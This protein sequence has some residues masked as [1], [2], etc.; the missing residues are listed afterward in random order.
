[1]PPG[2][3][4]ARRWNVHTF[5]SLRHRDFRV[6]WLGWLGVGAGQW[7][8]LLVV[9]WF[10]LE[11]TDSAFMVGAVHG[12]R[13]IPFLV[14]SPL[15]GV[16]ADRFDRRLLLA[17]SQSVGVLTASTMAFLDFSGLIEIWH[18]FVLTTVFGIGWSINNPVR[19]AIVPQLVEREDLM[20]AIALN[21][22][23]FNISRATGPLMAAV[24][25]ATLGFGHIFAIT[26]VLYAIV[27]M[28]ILSV[29]YRSEPPQALQESLWENLTG[30]LRYL[31]SQPTI[32]TLLAF[33]LFP[34]FVGMPYIALMPVFARDVLGQDELGFAILMTVAGVGSLFST[35]LL[36]S[37]A[38]L[39][40]PGM[41]LLGVGIVFASALIAFGFSDSF[42]LS[43]AI[44]GLLGAASMLYFSVSNILVQTLVS[45]A[46]R[47]RVMS[48]LMMEFGLLP[49]GALIVG[50]MADS[51][52]PGT[53]IIITGSI[54]WVA[55]VTAFIAFPKIRRLTINPVRAGSAAEGP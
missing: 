4:S 34:I 19:H 25:L 55:A 3:A 31:R 42:L 44:G 43:V 37:S 28:G 50:R 47:G 39:P 54:L 9:S 7:M 6:L 48:L 20:N 52:S 11:E 13:S 32:G 27:T 15:A 49:L 53:A 5:R 18:V 12:A 40:R 51:L 36:A 45:D 23:G 35:F 21:S 46:M 30:G 1:M 14:I 22:M 2:P 29:R 41:I 33:A 26:A 8:E 16:L 38:T 10:V 24:L 17:A